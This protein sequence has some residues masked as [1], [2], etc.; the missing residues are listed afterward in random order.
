MAKEAE[1]LLADSGW[2]PEPL[3]SADADATAAG[4]ASG[5]DDD[6]ALPAFLADDENEQSGE[7]ESDGDDPAMI[8]AE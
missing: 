7:G 2:L 4:G 5:G 1:R 3:R 8:A 6:E